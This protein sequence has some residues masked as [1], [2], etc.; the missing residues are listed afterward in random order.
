MK[1]TVQPESNG[2]NVVCLGTEW[3]REYHASSAVDPG[4][5]CSDPDPDPGNHV[6]SDPDP[7]LTPEPNGI[8]IYS[9]PDPT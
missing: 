9:D 3:K 4:R 7:D 8:R 2:L 6:H 1:G 5:L